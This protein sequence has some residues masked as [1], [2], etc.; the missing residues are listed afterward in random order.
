[1]GAENA[2]APVA[3]PFRDALRRAVVRVGDQLEPLQREDFVVKEDGRPQSLSTFEAIRVPESAPTVAQ[4][5]G[6]AQR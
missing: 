1:M 5:R 3:D 2:L 4:S 6:V